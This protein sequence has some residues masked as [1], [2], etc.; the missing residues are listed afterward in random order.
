MVQND[1]QDLEFAFDV[2]HHFWVDVEL[3]GT[4]SIFSSS[5]SWK[6]AYL[7]VEPSFDWDVYW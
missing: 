4:I 6:G 3:V 1:Q 5:Q 7:N 2:T